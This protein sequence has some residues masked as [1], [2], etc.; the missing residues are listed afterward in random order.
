MKIS[1]PLPHRYL[2]KGAGSNPTGSINLVKEG[3]MTTVEI[4]D[5]FVMSTAEAEARGMIVDALDGLITMDM[6]HNLFDAVEWPGSGGKLAYTTSR[7][8]TILYASRVGPP[9]CLMCRSN[10]VG[11]R[12]RYGLIRYDGL[13]YVRPPGLPAA[14][15]QVRAHERCPDGQFWIWD[16]SGSPRACA[17]ATGLK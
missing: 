11:E 14:K 12:E 4:A 13:W 5:V 6:V 10:M 3:T 2:A 17:V 1:A 16:W 7:L 15:V 9:L 8:W